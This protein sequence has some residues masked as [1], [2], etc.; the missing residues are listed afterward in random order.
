MAREADRRVVLGTLR[1]RARED[2]RPSRLPFSRRPWSAEDR[3]A[4]AYQFAKCLYQMTIRAAFSVGRLHIKE[5]RQR[6]LI[7][8][9]GVALTSKHPQFEVAFG[10]A[11]L[12]GARMRDGIGLDPAALVATRLRQETMPRILYGPGPR[13]TEWFP[14]R[15]EPTVANLGLAAAGNRR[16]CRRGPRS[17]RNPVGCASRIDRRSSASCTSSLR[18]RRIGGFTSHSK[19]LAMSR[20]RRSNTGT[21]ATSPCPSTTGWMFT[22]GPH[23]TASAGANH[24]RRRG[25]LCPERVGVQQ[26]T[27]PH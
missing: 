21:A 5:R 25:A 4:G 1:T 18:L 22:Q 9:L 23:R 14:P 16:R 15:P 11:R 7:G 20:K 10:T 27:G 17:H 8:P 24:D 19:R 13:G 12:F 26:F 2:S 6:W 3:P